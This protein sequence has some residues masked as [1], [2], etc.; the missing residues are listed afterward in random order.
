MPRAQHPGQKAQAH[1]PG[2]RQPGSECPRGH[3]QPSPVHTAGR[4]P[5]TPARAGVQGETQCLAPGQGSPTPKPDLH[6]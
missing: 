1:E 5:G 6:L 4:R 2:G 3:H